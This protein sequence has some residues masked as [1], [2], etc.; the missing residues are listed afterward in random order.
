MYEW[1]KDSELE[2][3]SGWQPRQSRTNY[4]TR[5]RKFLEEP[6]DDLAVFAIED[7]GEL[8]GRIELYQIDRRNRNAGMGLIIGEKNKWRRGIGGE[9]VRLILDYAFTV[10]SLEKV[11]AHV[12]SFNERAL[13]FMR[14][15]GFVEEGILRKHESHNG[16]LQDVHSF[17]MLRQEFYQ[18]H[19]TLFTIPQ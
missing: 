19:Q 15:A 5:F 17:G 8:V 13:R 2:I 10:E 6:P 9:A 7:S 1:H 4:D 3:L 11:Y 12:Y 18:R 14:K 16:E